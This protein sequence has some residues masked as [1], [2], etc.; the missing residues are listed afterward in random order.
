MRLSFFTPIVQADTLEG[1]RLKRLGELAE[2][3]CAWWGN[4]A[5]SVIHAQ[6]N[7][8]GELIKIE[9]QESTNTPHLST[10]LKILHLT[11]LF[12]LIMMAIK[13]AYRLVNHFVLLK[14]EDAFLTAD[15]ILKKAESKHPALHDHLALPQPEKWTAMKAQ[16]HYVLPTSAFFD[17]KNGFCSRYVLPTSF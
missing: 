13:V 10:A 9:V 8:K 16:M 11:L 5:Y 2:N 6:R 12:P 4:K 7:V 14:G 17:P 3:S 1:V 15:Q